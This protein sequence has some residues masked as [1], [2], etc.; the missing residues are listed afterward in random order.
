MRAS[1]TPPGYYLMFVIDG[2]GVPSMA[3]C[4]ASTSTRRRT[5]PLTTRPPLAAAAAAPFQLSCASD[6][7]TRRCSRPL[8]RPIVNQIG[9]RCVKI[10]QFG[11]WIGD[12]VNG[13]VT[14]TSTT[15]TAF[16][17]TCPRDFAVSGFRG[18]A[19]QYVDQSRLQCRALTASGGMTGR[20]LSRRPSAVPAGRRKVRSRAAPAIRSMRSTGAPAAGSTTSAC[21]AGAAAVTPDQHQF[22]ARDRQSGRA[23]RASSGAAVNLQIPASRRRRRHV[24]LQRYE[25][26]AGLTIVPSTGL[27]SRN[28]NGRRRLHTSRSRSTTARGATLPAFSGT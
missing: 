11:R 23:V 7:I 15:G 17:K 26:A 12:P 8:T 1:D 4:S 22:V 21:C 13:P 27:I 10:D 19:A 3:R 6:E 14:G 18:R 25:S 2:A 28:A 5:L 16:T 9:P 20:Q 24:D